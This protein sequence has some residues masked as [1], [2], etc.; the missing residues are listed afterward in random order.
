MCTCVCATARKYTYVMSFFLF[1]NTFHSYL[2]Y[3]MI[4]TFLKCLSSALLASACIFFSLEK[5]SNELFWF[6]YIIKRFIST[7]LNHWHF[8]VIRNHFPNKLKKTQHTTQIH[9]FNIQLR[10]NQFHTKK[11]YMKKMQEQHQKQT[12]LTA[13]MFN[14]P[15]HKLKRWKVLK[16]PFFYSLPFCLRISLFSRQP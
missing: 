10:S 12:N 16:L 11:I 15:L 4:L 5:F 2:S 8:R 7:T 6:H 9:N 1:A 3:V 13:N 14:N